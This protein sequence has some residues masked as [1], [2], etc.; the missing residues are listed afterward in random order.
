MKVNVG[1]WERIMRVVVGLVL[2]VAAAVG[3]T[4]AWAWIG[5]VPLATGI[6]GVCPAYSLFGVSTC[7]APEHKA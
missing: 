3:W 5:I 2:I 1:S 4:G 6:F 7:R